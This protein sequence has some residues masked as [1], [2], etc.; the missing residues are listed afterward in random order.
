[1]NQIHSAKDYYILYV[2]DEEKTLKYFS[3]FF[4]RDY[5]ILTA[6]NTSDAKS[7]LD[8]HADEIGLLISDQRMPV[9]KG[10]ELL[11]YSR[12]NYHR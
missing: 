4:S 6:Q 11:K 1:M 7:I 9:E 12:E 2:D 3:R 5:N 10:V 8:Q